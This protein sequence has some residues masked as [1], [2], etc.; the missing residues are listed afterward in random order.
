MYKKVIVL[1]LLTALFLSLFSMGA[2]SATESKD[3]RAAT[4][5]VSASATEIGELFSARSQGVH[6]RLIMHEEDFTEL[7]NRVETD[8]YS[9]ILYT[10]IYEYA[11]D[12]LTAPLCIYE[13]PDGER[14]LEISREASKRIVWCTI[15]YKVSGDR[16]FAD[17]AIE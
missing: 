10:R 8:P 14:L 2:V 17:R 11:E 7:R 16:R 12:Q 5:Q 4:T 6:P 13:L 1:A 9:K 15:V 3:T